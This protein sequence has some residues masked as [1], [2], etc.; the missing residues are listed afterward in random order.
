MI[1]SKVI[2]PESLDSWQ[3]DIILTL[4][5]LEIYFP[6][7]FFD[8]MVHLVSHIVVEIKACGL[9]F[10]RDMYPFERYMGFL[11]GFVRN[12]ARPDVSIVEGY[13]FEELIEFDA[14]YLDGVENISILGSRHEDKVTVNLGQPNVDKTMEKLGEGPKCVVR[15]YQGYDINGYTFYTQDQDENSTMQNSGVTVVASKIEFDRLNH[16]ARWVANN[17][18]GIKVDYNGF[19]LVDFSVKGY[20]SDTFILAKVATQV[21]FVKDPSSSRWH[22]VL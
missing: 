12:Q 3:K 21:F 17:A 8:I 13:Y 5:E 4:C 16:D 2:D 11:K 22:I 6:P 10:L 19:T 7:S 9:V 18:Q 14:D 15:S 20:A 1:H